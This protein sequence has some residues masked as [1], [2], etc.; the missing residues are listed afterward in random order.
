MLSLFR[1][2][3]TRRWSGRYLFFPNGFGAVLIDSV[4]NLSLSTEL[5][6]CI[7]RSM[8]DSRASLEMSITDPSL[9]V[10]LV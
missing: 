4:H 8:F 5:A 2:K 10:K 1:L 3:V 6:V 9:T 7:V